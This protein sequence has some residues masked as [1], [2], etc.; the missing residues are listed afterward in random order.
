MA[1]TGL[2]ARG[3]CLLLLA[4]SLSV[5]HIIQTPQVAWQRPKEPLLLFEC[6]GRRSVLAVRR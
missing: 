1:H 4:A 5:R 2:S 3:V 6:L